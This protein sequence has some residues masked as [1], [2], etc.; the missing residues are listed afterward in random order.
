MKDLYYNMPILYN[1]YYNMPILYKHV[2][3]DCNLS[4]IGLVLRSQG[5]KFLACGCCPV[6]AAVDKAGLLL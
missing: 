5:Q 6:T 2:L 4:V 3:L 1:L